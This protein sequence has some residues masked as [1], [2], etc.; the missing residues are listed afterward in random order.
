VGKKYSS[1]KKANDNGGLVTPF[2]K[3]LRGDFL[4][5]GI[6]EP[7]KTRTKNFVQL[8]IGFSV[9]HNFFVSNCDQPPPVARR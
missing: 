9:G 1:R 6:R 4:N 7:A 5:V 3:G 8:E 2:L